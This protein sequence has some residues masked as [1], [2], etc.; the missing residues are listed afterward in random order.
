MVSS[1]FKTPLSGD[2]YVVS[3]VRRALAERENRLTRYSV[4]ALTTQ[5]EAT[6]SHLFS[7]RS[8]NR[9]KGT[10]VRPTPMTLAFDGQRFFRLSPPEKQLVVYEV[11]LPKEKAAWFLTTQFAPFVAEGFR[12][13]LLPSSGLTARRRTASTG[14]EVFEVLFEVPDESGAMMTTRYELKFPSG[15]FILKETR[16]QGQTKT[17]RAE[18]EHCVA[19]WGVCVPQRVVEREND[20][21]VGTTVFSNIDLQAELPLDSFSVSAPEGFAVEKHQLVEE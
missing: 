6:A 3:E 4:E 7:Y 18:A 9:V 19:A 2:G 10:V 12:T 20:V 1:C 5:G 17:L 8:P 14:Q 16:L 11:K 13:P 21:L 15:D